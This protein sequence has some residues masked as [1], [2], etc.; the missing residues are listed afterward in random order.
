MSDPYKILGVKPDSSQDEIKKAY[1]TLAKKLH[2]DL[3]PGDTKIEQQFK[4][5][6]AAYDLLSDATK[7]AKYDRGGMNAGAGGAGGAS[8][9]ATSGFWKAWTSARKKQSGGFSDMFD[10]DDADMFDDILRRHGQAGG[11]SSQGGSAYTVGPDVNYKLKVS[12]AEAAAG[13]TKRVTLSDGKSLDLKIPPATES[14]KTLRLKGQGR[15]GSNS[16]PA[17]DA[18]VEI[19]VEPHD[20]FHRDGRNVKVEMPVT[21]YEAVLGGTITVPTVHGNVSLK[22]PPKSNTGATLRLKGKGVPAHGGKPAGD[23]LVTLKVVLP[24]TEDP[25]LIKLMQ[26][27]AEEKGYN[28]RHKMRFS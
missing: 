5:V 18:F 26:K 4:E 14:G 28:P 23:Q 20:Y 24:D 7:R 19:T 17:G 11:G 22:I 16:G 1:R 27:W 9:K 25:D 15:K 2:P 12:F 8:A 13:S 10:G 3:N 21:L 6:T